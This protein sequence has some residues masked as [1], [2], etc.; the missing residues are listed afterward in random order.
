MNEFKKSYQF[1]HIKMI[2]PFYFY[3]ILLI[4]VI[5]FLFLV[6]LF[7]ILELFLYPKTLN[8]LSYQHLLNIFST[9][10]NSHNITSD[11]WSINN[12]YNTKSISIIYLSHMLYMVLKPLK[13]NDSIMMCHPIFLMLLSMLSVQYSSN[14]KE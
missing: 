2:Y 7:V 14:Y 9:Q 3:N 6:L 5:S 8:E 1:Y 4:E 13:M 11:L 10:N 12:Q